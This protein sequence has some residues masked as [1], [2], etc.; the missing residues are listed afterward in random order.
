MSPPAERAELALALPAR[1]AQR[2]VPTNLGQHHQQAKGNDRWRTVW[3]AADGR[4]RSEYTTTSTVAGAAGLKG[5]LTTKYTNH[6]KNL[7]GDSVL[8]SFRV[9]GVFRG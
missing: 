1:T 6:T 5:F 7:A 3:R 2:A 9:F 4:A 8:R